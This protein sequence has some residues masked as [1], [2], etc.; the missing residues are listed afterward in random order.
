MKALRWVVGTIGEVLITLGLLLLLFVAWQLWWTDVAANREQAVTVQT[1][2]RGFGHDDAYPTDPLATP[3]PDP[4]ATPTPDPLATLT[5]DPLA[6]LK[7]VPFGEAFAI[8]RIPRF[9]ASFA[10]PVLQGTDHPTLGKGVGHYVGTTM[11]GLVGNFATAGHRTTY[12]RPFNNIDK[13]QKGDVIVVETK[14]SYVVYAVARHVIVTPDHVEVIAPVPQR[15][16]VAPTEAW[17]TMTACNPKYSAS[18]RYVVFAKLVKIIPRADG[19][20]AS[21]MAVPAGA[22]G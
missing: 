1:L 12:G 21:F 8:L 5:P 10:R 14:V 7:K 18:Q 22:V 13:L 3:T 19:L 16:G 20:P 4:S 9:G 17:M 11:P 2:E 15:P 6:T